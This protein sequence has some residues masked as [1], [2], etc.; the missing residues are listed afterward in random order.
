[1]DPKFF[2]FQPRPDEQ[3]TTITI[4][5]L[6]VREMPVGGENEEQNHQNNQAKQG[7]C[8]DTDPTRRLL[9]LALLQ[10]SLRLNPRHLPQN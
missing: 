7:D 6:P 3:Q 5:F 9:L 8:C 4:K 2:K 10:Q 1:M